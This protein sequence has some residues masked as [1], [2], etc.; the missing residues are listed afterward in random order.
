MPSSIIV[1][2]I[3]YSWTG[4][5]PRDDMT[6]KLSPD[7]RIPIR[8]VLRAKRLTKV[9]VWERGPPEV[10]YQL[11]EDDNGNSTDVFEFKS[12]EERVIHIRGRSSVDV[13]RSETFQQVA[14]EQVYSDFNLEGGEVWKPELN[15]Y[16]LPDDILSLFSRMN[17]RHT[18]RLES[19]R[20]HVLFQYLLCAM[21]AADDDGVMCMDEETH[22]E[23]I[24]NVGDQRVKYHG[25]VDFVVGHS[26]MHRKLLKDGIVI[27]MEMKQPD[28]LSKTLGQVL[29]GTSTSEAIRELSDPPRGLPSDRKTYFIFGDG[30]VWQFG[31]ILR[32][33]VGL[34]GKVFLSEV[35]TG[36]VLHEQI[37]GA[38]VPDGLVDEEGVKRVY[39]WMVHVV[40]EAKMS[41]P[42]ASRPPS[43]SGAQRGEEAANVESIAGKLGDLVVDEEQDGSAS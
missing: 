33:S 22:M 19:T 21:D 20:R 41:S 37:P 35:V 32:P 24:K 13:D 36:R 12:G 25:M 9:A 34:K 17:R 14:V 29:A 30:E 5:K 39:N 27:T 11:L 10:Q 16:S 26:M 2:L 15:S 4:T 43:A 31:Y 7:G 38:K 8:A 28:T 6:L 40:R 3:F 1:K 42:R 23:I 18:M